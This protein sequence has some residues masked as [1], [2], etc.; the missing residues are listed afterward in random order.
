MSFREESVDY[1]DGDVELRGFLV[2]DGHDAQRPGMLVVHGGAGLD[3]HARA[4]A[5]QMADLGLV[6]FACDMYG[7]AVIGDRDRVMASIKDLVGDRAKLCQRALAGVSVLA[8][9][10]G[11]NGVIGAVGYC[12]G[13]RVVLELARSGAKLAG[14]ISVHGSLETAHPARPGEVK[15]KI[16][17]CHGALDP[18]VAI[19]Q[20]PEFI[21]E[22]NAARTDYQL[23]V[24]GG[25]LHGFTHDVG[26]QAPGVAYH[27][28]SDQRSRLAIR[29]YL[30]EI[31]GTG[32][33][34]DTAE[35]RNV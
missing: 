25:A 8:S 30:G 32:M 1:C 10:R 19:A 5:R 34:S 27:A 23:I 11:V 3:D 9:H 13:G 33:P 15:A 14:V 31:L 4:R 24:Y 6:V 21:E 20:V 28:V 18:H 35:S 2:W 17:V 7:K 22:M 26:L 16:L 12:F 29:A